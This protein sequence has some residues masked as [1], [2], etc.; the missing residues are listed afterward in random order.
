MQILIHTFKINKIQKFLSED[1]NDKTHDFVVDNP[2]NLD[3][4]LITPL[5]LGGITSYFPFCKPSVRE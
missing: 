4:P 3:Q 5:V 2:I 1:P